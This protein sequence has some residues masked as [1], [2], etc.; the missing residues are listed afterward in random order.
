M[1]KR[2]LLGAAL[3]ALFA[4]ACGQGPDLIDRTQ[5][6]YIRK[7]ELQAGEWYVMDTVVD[8]PPTS[9]LAFIGQ[10]GQMD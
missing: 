2:S 8:V 3:V 4:A 1:Q 6:N 7:S 9:P 5:P 10:Q